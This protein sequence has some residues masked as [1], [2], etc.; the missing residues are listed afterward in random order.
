MKIKGIKLLTYDIPNRLNSII[1]EKVRKN[2]LESYYF[3]YFNIFISIYDD[4][5]F[6]ISTSKPETFFRLLI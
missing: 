5:L 2:I 4:V 3:M 1:P 6:L